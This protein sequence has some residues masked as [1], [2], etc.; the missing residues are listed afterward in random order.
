MLAARG[1]DACRKTCASV[2]V[3]RAEATALSQLRSQAMMS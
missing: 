3:K 1:A 2:E